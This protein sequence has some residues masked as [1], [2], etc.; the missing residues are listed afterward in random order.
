MNF[1]FLVFGVT[2]YVGK[3]SHCIMVRLW[4]VSLAPRRKKKLADALEK[5]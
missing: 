2:D 3:K 4:L 1:G 5:D